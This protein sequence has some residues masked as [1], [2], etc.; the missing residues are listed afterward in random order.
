MNCFPRLATRLLVVAVLTLPAAGMTIASAQFQPPSTV[1][2]SVADAAGVVAAGVPIEAITDSVQTMNRELAKGGKGPSDALKSLGLA[3]GQL[4]GLQADEQIALIADR[5]KDLGLDAGQASAIMQGLGIR[6]KEFILA[7][8]DGGDA[9]REAGADIKDYGLAI[10]TID[11][12]KIE[13]LR[14]PAALAYGGQAI[15]GVVN[16][17]TDRPTAAPHAIVRGQAGS[18]G[19]YNGEVRATGPISDTSGYAASVQGS[20]AKGFSATTTPGSTVTQDGNGDG[21][22]PD[23]YDKGGARLRVFK[24]TQRCAACVQ[25]L[26]NTREIGRECGIGQLAVRC[27]A[28]IQR[29]RRRVHRVLR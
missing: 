17:L 25:R 18:Y 20:T 12:D 4:K 8:M 24:R 1:F 3:A 10:S 13:I 23:G 16:Y 2:G 9:I 15:G 21:N 5:I 27:F 29:F 26:D 22:E 6:S 28:P 14:G 19:V 11:A 7:V